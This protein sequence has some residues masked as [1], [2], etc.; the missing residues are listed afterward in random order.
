MRGRTAALLIAPL[1]LAPLVATAQVTD[2]TRTNPFSEPEAA[3]TEPAAPPLQSPAP[4]APCPQTA[5]PIGA[6]QFPSE[7]AAKQA[8]GNDTVVWVNMGGSRAWHVSGDRYYGRTK[9]GAYT[10]EKAAQHAG[11]HASGRAAARARRDAG[12]AH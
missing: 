9:R 10:C 11:Y 12:P 5:R 1:L 3:P 7:E 6:N 2:T 8:C 4:R